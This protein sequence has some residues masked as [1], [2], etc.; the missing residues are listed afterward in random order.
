MNAGAW[1]VL[2]GCWLPRVPRT[3]LVLGDLILT[4]ARLSSPSCRV[5]LTE[6]EVI[7]KGHIDRLRSFSRR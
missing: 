6:F 1:D 7:E 4:E 3:L 5:R 2:A